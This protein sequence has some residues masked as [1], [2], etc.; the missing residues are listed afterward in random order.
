VD[1]AAAYMHW[2]RL[3][4]E[5]AELRVGESYNNGEEI[6]IEGVIK[7]NACA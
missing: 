7:I 5:E 1:P 2:I 6:H 4:W 3:R